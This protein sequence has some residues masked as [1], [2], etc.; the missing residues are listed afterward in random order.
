M[1]MRIGLIAGCAALLPVLGGCG[2]SAIT[3][4]IG[5]NL[6]GAE[7]T[8]PAGIPGGPVSPEQTQ[9]ALNNGTNNGGFGCPA[10][11]VWT[12]DRTYTVYEPGREGDGLAI[13]HRGELM[14]TGR[15]CAI[16]PGQIRVK[17]GVFGRVLLGPKGQ[18]GPL[19]LPVRITVVNV[20]REP[21]VTTRLQIPVVVK[22]GKPIEYFT[23][24]GIIDFD[25]PVGTR[26]ADYK[27]LVAFENAN[28][29]Q[30]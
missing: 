30:G 10:T 3:S 7:E 20:N 6:F 14:K 21:V 25:V 16:Q 29:P 13:V 24:T 15:E 22:D 26:P 27:L 1:H 12:S 11:E 5:T 28:T 23:Q 4:G 17:Y 2:V 18:A 9:L 19:N 8:K